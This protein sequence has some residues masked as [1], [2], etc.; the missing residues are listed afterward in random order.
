MTDAKDDGLIEKEEEE[1]ELVNVEQIKIIKKKIEKPK[2]EKQ[3]EASKKAGER[4]AKIHE[5]K[6]AEKERIKKEEEAKIIAELK[7]KWTKEYEA[8]KKV[9][10]NT[11]GMIAIPKSLLKKMTERKPKKVKIQ[12]PAPAPAPASAQ[13]VKK[14][15][16]VDSDEEED[17]TD[18]EDDHIPNETDAETTDTRVIKKKL[19]KVKQIEQVVNKQAT[20]PYLAMLEKWYK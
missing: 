19:A 18:S 16:Q 15:I 6:R 13:K 7:E 20:N 8:D 5:M 11:K 4:L 12:T 2:T 10:S 14:Q 17:E 1:E 3:I 9:E